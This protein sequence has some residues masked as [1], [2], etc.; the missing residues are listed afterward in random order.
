MNAYALYIID[1]NK[2]TTPDEYNKALKQPPHKYFDK[3]HDI[4]SHHGIKFNRGRYG[5][6]ATK[7]NT[8]Y[9]A[10]KISV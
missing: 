5:H 10:F 8:D 3:L 4:E 2:I 6:Y 9:I 1:L 7:G